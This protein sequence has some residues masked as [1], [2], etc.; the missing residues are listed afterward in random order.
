MI[1]IIIIICHLT[2]NE[3]VNE[4]KPGDSIELM[5]FL[6]T[7]TEHTLPLCSESMWFHCNQSAAQKWVHMVLFSACHLGFTP[8]ILLFSLVFPFLLLSLK[9]HECAVF[10]LLQIINK[11][12]LKARTW[13][14]SPSLPL[15]AFP[16]WCSDEPD[17]GATQRCSWPW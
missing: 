4:A 2:P 11:A 17:C 16:S 8:I 7:S 10:F 14:S 13:L 5:H 6:E 15:G 3:A 9:L 12:A 1:N